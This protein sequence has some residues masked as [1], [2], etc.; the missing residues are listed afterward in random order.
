VQLNPIHVSGE[1]CPFCE[2]QRVLKPVRINDIVWHI[3]KEC[4]IEILIVWTFKV[5][6]KAEGKFDEKLDKAQN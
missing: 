4:E 5:D 6:T 1:E 3:C 2:Q